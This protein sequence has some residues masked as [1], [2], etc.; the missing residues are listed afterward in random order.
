[1]PGLRKV[2]CT[3]ASS[4][5]VVVHA[6]A[7]PEPLRRDV[8]GGV[9]AV[10]CNRGDVRGCVGGFGVDGCGQYCAKRSEAM[11]MSILPKSLSNAGVE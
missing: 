11:T 7:A 6:T 1:M 8:H 9:G 4:S 10:G 2:R 5:G 3:K